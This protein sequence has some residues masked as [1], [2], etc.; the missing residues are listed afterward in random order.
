VWAAIEEVGD[1]A[2]EGGVDDGVDLISL[3]HATLR[4]SPYA[5]S[6]AGGESIVD[7]DLARHESIVRD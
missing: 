3:V 7:R 2:G 5:R 4:E 1:R 6:L